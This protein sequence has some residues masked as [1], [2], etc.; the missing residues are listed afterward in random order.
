MNENTDMTATISVDD[1]WI[2]EL[3]AECIAGLERLLAAHA[4]FDEFLRSRHDSTRWRSHRPGLTQRSSVGSRPATGRPGRSSTPSTSRGSAPSATGSRATPTTR[5]ISPRRPSS[6]RCPRS[7]GSIP[8]RVDLSAYLFA[9]TKNL[10]LK[11]VE[12]AKRAEPT[13]E[14]P[15]PDLPTAI[16]DDPERERAPAPPAGGGAARERPA[17]AAPAPRARALRARGPVVRRDRRARRPQRER[18]RAARLPRPRAPPHRAAARPGRPG[19]AC[20]RSAAH[21]CRSSRSTSTAS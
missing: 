3:A 6:G 16:E 19:V 1:A 8:T 20:P 9:T 11:Q 17:R 13:A 7:T 12:R 21:S 14:V 15:E 2:R 18:R 10:F 4:A 5:T